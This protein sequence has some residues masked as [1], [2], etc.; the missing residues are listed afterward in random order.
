MLGL[1]PAAGDGSSNAPA[2]VID[3]PLAMQA[4]EQA[5]RMQMPTGLV[6]ICQGAVMLEM[7]NK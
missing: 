2:A 4:G 7:L 3:C 5:Q 1:Q 6:S